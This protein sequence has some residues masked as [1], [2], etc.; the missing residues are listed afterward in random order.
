MLTLAPGIRV[1]QVPEETPMRPVCTNI[2][3]VGER[4]L[5]LIDTG[6]DE[7]RYVRAMFQGLVE[8]G[9]EHEVVAAAITH[10]HMDH[11][12]GLRWVRETLDTRL[13]AHPD[14][15][16]KVQPRLKGATI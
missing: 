16:P 6:V 9:Q 12:G 2:Y 14:A 4:R 8:L 11:Q 5:T 7:P 10:S 3:L 1:I 13:F 15:I